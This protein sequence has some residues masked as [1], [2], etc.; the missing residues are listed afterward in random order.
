M[1]KFLVKVVS[2]KIVPVQPS[3]KNLIDKML[4]DYEALDKKFYVTFEEVSKD[5]NESQV[6]L[7][8]AFIVRASDYFGNTYSEMEDMLKRYHPM[9]FTI[10]SMGTTDTVPIDKWSSEDLDR[11]INQASAL[12]SP[13]GFK[14]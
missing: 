13:H 2:G 4:R 14:F 7:Y 8:R 5:L 1:H 10:A 12:L 6:G 3:K 11:F 9:R